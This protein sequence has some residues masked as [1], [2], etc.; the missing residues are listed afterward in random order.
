MKFIDRLSWPM[1]IIMG[2]FLAIAPY[3]GA[4][5]PHSIEKIQML[6]DGS[7]SK[8]IDI[9]D[10]IMHTAPIILGSIK[11][12]RQFILKITIHS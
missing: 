10:L 6:F 5:M 11:A 4:P 2:G 1:I 9:F 7:L 8:P 3:P 12:Y